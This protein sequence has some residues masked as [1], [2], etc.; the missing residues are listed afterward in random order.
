[1]DQQLIIVIVICCLFI[2]GYAVFLRRPTS[3]QT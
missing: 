1:M 3:R 2:V